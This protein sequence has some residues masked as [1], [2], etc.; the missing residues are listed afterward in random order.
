MGFGESP[1]EG[2]P[3]LALDEVG[4]TNTEA[5]ARAREGQFGPLWISARRQTGGRGRRGRV[6]ASEPG[7][8]YASL[9]LTDP[10]PS[11]V[12]PQLC[13]VAGLALHDAVG[14]LCGLE[15]PRLALKWPNDLML[16]GAK[17]AGILVE[18]EVAPAG[19]PLA[20]VIGFGVNCAHHP[21]DTP[22]QAI[23]LAA[24]AGRTIAPAVLLSALDA[25]MAVRLGEWRGGSAF[26]TTRAHWLQRAGRVGQPVTVR[27]GT[28]VVEGRFET[29]DGDGAM[30]LLRQDGSRT[31]IGTG[32]ILPFVGRADPTRSDRSP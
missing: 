24:A 2:T 31:R 6:W 18:G 25:A 19:R 8:L 21:D 4:S 28:E 29:L 20:V 15:A 3:V 10:A 30:V 32:E 17:C 14:A 22:Y 13:F 7:N 26:A 5:L 9:L 23:D 12:C 27:T 11:E 1:G 16:D